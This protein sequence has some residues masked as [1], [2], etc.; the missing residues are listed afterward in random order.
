MRNR[1]RSD[2]FSY[3][4]IVILLSMAKTRYLIRNMNAPGPQTVYVTARFGRNAKLM[5]ALPLKCDPIYWDVVKGRVKPTM[6]CP[7]RDEVNEALDHL[8]MAFVKF[9]SDVV[10]GGGEVSKESLTHLLDVHFGK[11][12]EKA[13]TFHEFFEE[14][15]EACRTRM[16]VKR[17][18]QVVTYN[19][20]REYARTLIY[21]EQYEEKNGL[22]LDFQDIDQDFLS[23]F[24]AFLQGLNKA[25]NTISHKVI[26][27]KAVMRAACE[28]GL[29]DNERWKFYRNSTEQTESVALSEEELGR[30]HDYDFSGDPRLER[31]RDLFLVGCW[32]GLRF[33]DVTRIR[34]EN[35]MDGF[36]D[37]TQSK[38]YG[39]VVIPLHPVFREIWDKYGG[40]LPTDISNQKFND[41]I[42]EVCRT[43][44]LKEGVLKSITKGGR[45]ITTRYEKWQ[46]VSS[47]T[48]RR[49]FATNLYK[50][51][52]PSISIMQITGHKTETAFLKYIKVSKQEHA[53]LLA[54]HWKKA[55]GKEG[56][57]GT[58]R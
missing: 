55:E 19:T 38:T 21:I 11:I 41:Y 46:L 40:D 10:G 50:S 28:R 54:D 36:I 34:R 15:I 51:G 25:T 31:V 4:C 56:T 20:R 8:E 24:V 22:R 13:T 37:I 49:S 45:L 12:K 39:R 57:D 58:H 17:G 33:S 35:I 5:Y 2:F 3:L 47:H 32:T 53:R 42:K 27:I 1:L 52:F 6:Y 29:T 16:N 18:G 48:A 9:A 23:S 26:C 43:V 14:F 7:Y 30:I 44:G